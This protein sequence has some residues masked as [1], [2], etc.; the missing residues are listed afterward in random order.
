MRRAERLFRL[1]K[2][3]R[4]RGTSRA[5]D[6]AAV[7]DVSLRTIYRDIA[8]LQA[9]GLPIDGQAGVGY[10]IRPGFDLPNMTFTFAQMD[11]LAIGLAFAESLDD[12]EIAAAA[13]EARAKIQAS[14]P[15]P[16][17]GK[18]AEAPYFALRKSTGAPD[19]AAC[20]RKAIRKRQVI[21]MSYQDGEGRVSAR[22]VRPLAILDFPEGWMF[23]GWCELRQDMRTFRLDRIGFLEL[24]P[25]VFIHEDGKDLRAWLARESCATV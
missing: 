16:E 1:I 22:S 7:L 14:L 12:P 19:H 17:A 8:H 21:R 6:L 15:N 4:V 9:S 3:L 11:A 5:E 18:L 10:L 23:S 24:T 13:R 2:Q 20:L 25:E